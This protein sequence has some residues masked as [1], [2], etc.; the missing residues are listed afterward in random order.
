[1]VDL[2]PL[3][4]ADS[5]SKEH[6]P[7]EDISTILARIQTADNSMIALQ[8]GL[9]EIVRLTGVPRGVLLVKPPG[10]NDVYPLVSCG[11][12]P[13]R[14]FRLIEPDSLFNNWALSWSK[15]D[16]ANWSLIPLVVFGD[17]AG[18]IYL[19]KVDVF[20]SLPA[21]VKPVVDA[22]AHYLALI[23]A[24]LNI[25]N[26]LW[27]VTKEKTTMLQVLSTIGQIDQ[28]LNTHFDQA[29]IL[30]E[31]KEACYFLLNAERCLIWRVDW[32]AKTLR[33]QNGDH[34]GDVTELPLPYSVAGQAAQ[35]GKP[36]LITGAEADSRFSDCVELQP[37]YETR[38]LICMPLRP[39]DQ[40]LW[41]LEVFN[42]LEGRFDQVDISLTKMLATNA[43]IAL[44]NA[45]R[46]ASRQMEA[47][48]NAEI[49][50]VASHGLRS[51]LMS[52]LTSIEW[53]L[54]NGALN[55]QQKARLDDIRLQT[56]NL[57]QF[58][59][60]IL[61]LSR[62]E[63]DNM[64]PQ[65]APLA[66]L[67][68]VKRVLTGFEFRAREHRFA[69]RTTG[70]IPPV[71]ADETQISIVLDHLLENA[72]RYSPAGTQI[73]VDIGVSGSEVAVAVI[74]AGYGIPPQE[75]DHLF[76][77]FFRGKQHSTRQSLGLG[78]YIVKKLVEAHGGCVD[79][80][81]VVDKGTCFRFTLPQEEILD[82]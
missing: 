63:T 30:K 42:K 18:A 71:R 9:Q 2:A 14:N 44:E 72:V 45:S 16:T 80:E 51:P 39:N 46:Q 40:I 74:D 13:A 68:L 59:T 53:M 70:N 41:V 77:R 55:D 38:Q 52:V 79:V 50:T 6:S 60:K 54:E 27:Q 8:V 65:L 31:L 4:K 35:T 82:L 64:T 58:A 69:L 62:I 76:E 23:L 11:N 33:L 67:P 3:L 75:I 36:I 49:Y 12:E 43:S 57:S 26:Q 56:V 17:K 48:Q 29:Q 28:R 15:I 25:N 1:M 10:S 81:S 22:L 19:N 32:P 73:T 61:D 34:L 21:S 24:H 37:E 66:L 20:S 5:A 7:E 78:L 47:Q